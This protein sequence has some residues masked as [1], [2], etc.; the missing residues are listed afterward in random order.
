[1]KNEPVSLDVSIDR[2]VDF[3]G[4]PSEYWIAGN[5]QQK[6][7]VQTLMFTSLIEYSKDKGYGIANFSLPFKLLQETSGSNSYLVEMAGIKRCEGY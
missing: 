4:N 1:M 6:R 7:L 3:M 5:L 2:V